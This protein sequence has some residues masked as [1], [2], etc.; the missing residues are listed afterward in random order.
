[1]SVVTGVL[2]LFSGKPR[3]PIGEG[4]RMA[5]ADH[6]RELRA[7][8]MRVALYLV[9]GTI[10]ALFFYDALFQLILDPYNQAREL[11]G[12]QTQTQAVISG[13]GTPL[14]LQLKICAVAG[15]VAT[16]PLW[17]YEIWAFIVPGLHSQE[18]RWTR[19][20]AVVAG[21]LF[22]AGVAMG[23]YVLP[24]GIATL[25]GFTPDGLT[26]LTDFGDFYSFIA[27]MLLVFGIAFEIPLFVVLLNLAGVVS[28]RAL[29][30]Y[31]PWIIVGTFVF[32]A[33]ATPSTDPF[34]MLML[35]IPM[36]VLL[37]VSEMIARLIDR[38][39]GRHA[40]EEWDDDT[41]SPL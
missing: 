18:K 15:V 37:L 19:L 27:R 39:R 16:S 36:L 1:M 31:R 23:Y 38:R 4:G 20:F 25:I 21:P 14:L 6:F 8:I 24:K 2:G 12:Q 32:A 35:A 41:A 26:Q 29:G 5:L 28:G 9:L 3:N 17:L 33:V 11:L 30:R 13:V 40:H 7:R 10:I 22:I 34:S